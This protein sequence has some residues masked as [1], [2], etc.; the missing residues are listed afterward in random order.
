MIETPHRDVPG[1]FRKSVDNVKNDYLLE[2]LALQQDGKGA[3]SAPSN[4]TTHTPLLNVRTEV[5]DV[6]DELSDSIL[7]CNGK[8]QTARW[9]FFI[10]SPGNG[11]SAAMG[12]LCGKLISSFECQVLDEK[13]VPIEELN[14]TDIPYVVFVYEKGNRYASARVVQDA[15]VV[16]N[17]FS[18]NVDPALDLIDTLHDS[19]EKGVSLVI[20]TNRGVLE[21]A[22]WDKHT[23]NNINSETWFKILKLIDNESNTNLSGKLTSQ[24]SFD[25][26]KA[27]FEKLIVS[28]HYLENHSLLLG[29]STFDELL[30][31]ATSQSHWNNCEL[32]TYKKLCP[33]KANRDW[34]THPE[35]KTPVLQLLK[36]AE[37]L[38]GQV[39][40]FR[41]A[42]ALIS[43]FLAGCPEDYKGHGIHP[44]EW[45]KIKVQNN[46][47]FSLLARRIYMSLFG[48]F[49]PHGLEM[50]DD[51]R[52][53]QIDSLRILGE[54]I[55]TDNG[56]A[57]DALNHVICGHS[58]STDVGVTR[59]LGS[60]GVI[61]HIDPCREVLPWE[62]YEQWDSDF[63][64]I[65]EIDSVG[66]G[67]LEKLCLSI[68]KTL[69]QKIEI[70][71]DH[72]TTQMYWAVRRWSSNFLLHL[73]AL[74]E[75]RS[76]YKSELDEFSEL[77]ELVAKQKD[78]PNVETRDKVR[79]LENQLEKLLDSVS[80]KDSSGTVDLSNT[81]TLTG[82]WVQSNLKPKIT[83]TKTSGCLYLS[84]GFNENEYASLNALM[85][86]W[87]K[88]CEEGKLDRR[89][90][91]LELL[92][93]V[94]DARVRTVSKGNY[95][96]EDNDVEL[97]V[98]IT[99]T[100]EPFWF[101]I[102]RLDG[103]VKVEMNYE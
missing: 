70:T 55:N 23:D 17:P 65:N 56:Q 58:P 99:E 93:G 21:K 85:F 13:N 103:D 54:K 7:K 53:G 14:E 82:D 76:A 101:E 74:V 67:E 28:Y 1:E 46:D 97:I 11:K 52:H 79:R 84:I 57:K 20:C 38:S 86:L 64:A 75:D 90:F 2:L 51:I 35:L 60:N 45:V 50:S 61:A 36:R 95:A 96:F 89:C 25:D 29:R 49:Y 9:H 59:L 41:E 80:N 69:E 100:D 18:P 32:C 10:G 47:A 102:R 19:W 40:V 37:V 73:G 98:K 15:S 44:C 12:K 94:T 91:P 68:W 24:F 62:F 72:W 26:K 8:N 66:F 27:V 43:L 39:I 3:I 48:S 77:L 87:L 81:V 71:V 31:K 33:F 63:D 30:K 92:T 83:T 34:L 42:L 6:V 78:Q 4:W 22:I 5:D 88:R 16:R